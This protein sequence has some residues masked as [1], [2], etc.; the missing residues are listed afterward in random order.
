MRSHITVTPLHPMYNYY[1]RALGTLP[2][3]KARL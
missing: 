1:I 3:S 2:P